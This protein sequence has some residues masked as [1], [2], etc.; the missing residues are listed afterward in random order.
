MRMQRQPIFVTT[1][2]MISRDLLENSQTAVITGTTSRGIFIRLDTDWVLFLSFESYHGPLTLNLSGVKSILKVVEV[3]DKLVTLGEKILI[4][5]SGIKIDYSR[6]ERWEALPQS[7]FSLSDSDRI[8]SLKAIAR[9]IL[10]QK[11]EPG[12]YLVLKDMLG[13]QL[14]GL[15][16]VPETFERVDCIRL[17]YLLKTKDLAGILSALSPFLGLGAGLTPSGDD[18][19]LGLLLAYRRWGAVLKTAFDLAKLNDRLTQAA[20][21]KTTLLSANLITCASQGQADERLINALDGI[22]TGSPVPDQCAQDLSNWGNSSGCDALVGMALA[23][24]STSA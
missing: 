21:L 9:L 15:P 14:A 1:Q 12:L 10:S 16:L 17:L 7:G 19:I 4:P 5:S 22:M 3:N 8:G 24:L 2:G 6:A 20:S 23:I 18:M 11:K 13:I